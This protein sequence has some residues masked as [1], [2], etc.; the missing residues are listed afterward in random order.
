MGVKK[1]R[2]QVHL[3]KIVDSSV[4]EAGDIAAGAVDT[5]ELATDAVT[6]DKLGPAI[7]KSLKFQYDF[8]DLGGAV[9][10]ITLTDDANAALTIPDNAVIIGCDIEMLTAFT[11]GGSATVAV[12]YTGQ[13]DDFL[14]ALAMDH[15]SWAIAKIKVAENDL[16]VKTTAA[17]SVLFTIATA[18]LTAGKCNLW[19][20]FFEGDA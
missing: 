11:S 6:I 17:V 4:I 18:A 3:A 19:V 15:A 7:I 1:F 2:K 9:G 14:A 12:G 13:T 8:A 5:S 20:R 16:P 10:A